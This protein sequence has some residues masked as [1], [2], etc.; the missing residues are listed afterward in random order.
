MEPAKQQNT[1]ASKPALLFISLLGGPGSGKGT[2]GRWLQDRYHIEHVSMGDVMR[3][4]MEREG[5]PHAEAIRECMREGTLGPK[6]V[7][8]ALL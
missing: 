4:E 1:A 3:A 5:S 2:V 8:I 6:E 7:G